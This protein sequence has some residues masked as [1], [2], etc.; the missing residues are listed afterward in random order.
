MKGNPAQNPKEKKKQK[1][2]GLITDKTT[3]GVL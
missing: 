1:L 2:L 3:R